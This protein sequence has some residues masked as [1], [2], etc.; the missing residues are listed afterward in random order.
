MN[1][2]LVTDRLLNNW[3]NSAMHCVPVK[4]WHLFNCL[5]VTLV[6][7]ENVNFLSSRSQVAAKST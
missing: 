3:V 4:Y 1:L 7:L 6:T 2:F 5:H